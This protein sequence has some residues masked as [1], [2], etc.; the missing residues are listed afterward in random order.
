MAK[1]DDI[2]ERLMR[3]SVEV[4]EL[5]DR[6]P[7]SLSGTHIASQLVRSASS[8]APNYAEARAAESR[9]DFVHKLGIVFKELN[10]SE[11]WLEMLLKKQ[12]MEEDYLHSVRKECSELCRII[13][14]SRKT[15]STIQKAPP[16]G[17]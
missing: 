3:F 16:S 15:A 7:K 12:V 5:C 9:R 10:E 6:I 4:M 17:N 2:Q 14:S 1:G 13:A 8:A 11:V